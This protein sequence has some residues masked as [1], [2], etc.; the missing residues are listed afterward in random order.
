MRMLALCLV[1]EYLALGVG[2]A[3]PPE[4][5]VVIRI[6]KSQSCYLAK[7]SISCSAIPAKLNTMKL[8][9]GD[10]ILV[11]GGPEKVVSKMIDALGAAGYH[12]V[13][14]FYETYS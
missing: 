4:P 13:L 11:K 14:A 2:Y 10:P 1:L 8:S 12:N 3:S 6:T 5:R 7:V 9:S